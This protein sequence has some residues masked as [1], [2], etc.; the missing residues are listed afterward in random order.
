MYMKYACKYLYRLS[1]GCVYGEHDD[2]TSV[3]VCVCKKN[4]SHVPF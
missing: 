3:C 1:A 2:A 4:M